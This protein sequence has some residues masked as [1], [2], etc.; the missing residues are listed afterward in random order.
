MTLPLH[1]EIDREDDG[2]W[3]ADLPAQHGHP[4]TQTYGTTPGQAVDAALFA[5]GHTPEAPRTFTADEVRAAQE[6]TRE[7]CLEAA[8]GASVAHDGRT[9][10]RT[11]G[12][13]RGAACNAI[14]SMSLPSL[15]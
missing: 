1:V 14:R 6:A 3:I 11:F 4:T 2:R 12:G 5:A 7:A 9:Y 15:P 10:P 13:G 8:Q